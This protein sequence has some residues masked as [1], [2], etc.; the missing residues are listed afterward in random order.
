M[1]CTADEYAMIPGVG[2]R[3]DGPQGCLGMAPQDTG[4]RSRPREPSNSAQEGHA[5]RILVLSHEMCSPSPPSWM[6]MERE[7]DGMLPRADGMLPRGD[8]MLATNRRNVGDSDKRPEDAELSPLGQ[9]SYA[10]FL[11]ERPT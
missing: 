3:D 8:G 7:L 9:L 1:G 11:R 4:A 10:I 5:C 6:P 2:M